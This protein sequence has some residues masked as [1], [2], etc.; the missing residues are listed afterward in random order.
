MCQELEAWLLR[1]FQGLFDRFPRRMQRELGQRG[2]MQPQQP[3]GQQQPQA[4]GQ[5]QPRTSWQGMAFGG[6]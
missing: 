2:S 4:R 1:G 6:A 3:I 5:Q